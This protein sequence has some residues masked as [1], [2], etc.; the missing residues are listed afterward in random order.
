MGTRT[1]DGAGWARLA[2]RLALGTIFIVSGA[3]KLA[4]WSGTAAFAASKGVP[5]L[6]LAGAVALELLGGASLALGYR[7]RWGA[8]AL[9]AFLVPVTLVFHAFWASPAAEVQLQSIQFLKNLAIAGG[10][11][12]V[13]AVGPG[14]LSVDERRARR[15]ATPAEQVR[16]AA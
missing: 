9:L 10:L 7:T 5:E 6:L 4:A 3:G 11:A 15:A 14:A 1:K 13:A 12:G 2:G 8:L 16:L